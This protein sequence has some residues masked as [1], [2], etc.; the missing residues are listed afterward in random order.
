MPF[1]AAAARPGNTLIA[2]GR[3][4][5]RASVPTWQTVLGW[6][7]RSPAPAALVEDIDADTVR[8]A[9]R[10]TLAGLGGPRALRVGRSIDA[11]DDLPALWYLRA[12]LLQAIASE[13]G[14]LHARRCLAAI[15][16]LFRRAWPDA[17]VSRPAT[18]A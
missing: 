10:G 7:R 11:C 16:P 12:G 5:Q 15:D 18:L 2:G 17:P 1:S 4:P 8:I 3:L 6:L 9:M 14:E 13:R